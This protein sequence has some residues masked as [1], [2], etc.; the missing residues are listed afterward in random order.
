MAVIE[1]T[2]LDH[3]HLEKRE[4]ELPLA[5]LVQAVGFDP[6][7]VTVEA[8]SVLGS[9]SRQMVTMRPHERVLV[10][11]Q[12]VTKVERSRVRAE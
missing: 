4:V 5:F 2:V 9:G 12:V 7:H 1:G 6:E 11:V 10:A 8:V 3:V